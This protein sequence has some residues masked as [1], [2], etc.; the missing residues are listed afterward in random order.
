[1]GRT[2]LVVMLFCFG[3]SWNASGQINDPEDSIPIAP[4][5]VHVEDGT[6]QHV[7]DHDG[8]RPRLGVEHRALFDGRHYSCRRLYVGTV[9]G[10]GLIVTTF[11]LAQ[12]SGDAPLARTWMRWAK[13]SQSTQ[14]DNQYAF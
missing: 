3:V 6:R 10:M 4:R 7:Q 14:D 11:M 1:M 2:F 13:R 9:F 5:R 12:S 8:D